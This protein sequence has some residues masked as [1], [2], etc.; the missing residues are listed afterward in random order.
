MMNII[1]FSDDI[2]LIIL[3]K[4]KNV[5]VLYSLIGTEPTLDRLA[6]DF[7]FTRSVNLASISSNKDNCSI[8]YSILNRFYTEIIPRIQHNIQCLTLDSLSMDNALRIGKYLSL[9]RLVLVNLKYDEAFQLF[10]S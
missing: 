9:E 7:L 5:D 2:L 8:S 6:Q 4:L 10:S 3:K 1:D